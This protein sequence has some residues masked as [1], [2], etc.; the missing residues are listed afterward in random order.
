MVLE[1]PARQRLGG[2]A[3]AD[4]GA[5]V[6]EIRV[7]V[8]V[9]DDEHPLVRMLLVVF[10][11]LGHRLEPQRRLAAPLLTE[12]QGRRGIAR[13]AEELVPGG[14]VDRR[15][16]TPLEDRVGLRVLFA[17]RVAGDPVVPQELVDLH[18]DVH[19]VSVPKRA[20]T[21][22]GWLLPWSVFPS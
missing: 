3:G 9:G 1:P 11:Q 21:S 4:C 14:M 12:D 16:T 20:R 8:V 22:L 18:R 13:T 7:E 2:V 6:V 5:E 19:S 17:E 15:E 10:L